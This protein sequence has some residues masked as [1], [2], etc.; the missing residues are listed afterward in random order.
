MTI[1]KINLTEGK[2]PNFIGS[3]EYRS[4]YMQQFN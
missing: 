2:A 1:K 4:V 3:W